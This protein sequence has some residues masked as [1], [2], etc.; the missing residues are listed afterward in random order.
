MELYLYALNMDIRSKEIRFTKN[1]YT[2]ILRET[3]NMITIQKDKTIKDIRKKEIG[4]IKNFGI[5][6]CYVY[7]E[8]NDDIIFQ[9]LKSHFIECL[10]KHIKELNEVQNF[11]KSNKPIYRV[12]NLY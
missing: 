11:I 9:H 6:D 2:N 4:I 7:H 8:K 12:D 1:C 5:F 3:E 10:E